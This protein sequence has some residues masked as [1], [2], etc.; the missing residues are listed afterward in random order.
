MLQSFNQSLGWSHPDLQKLTGSKEDV[1]PLIRTYRCLVLALE[2][3]DAGVWQRWDAERESPRVSRAGS[4][5]A[6]SSA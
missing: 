2:A 5:S 3:A 6:Q 4:L 1:I